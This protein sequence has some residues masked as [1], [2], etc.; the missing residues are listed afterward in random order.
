MS[1]VIKFRAWGDRNKV[2]TT[3]YIWLNDENLVGQSMISAPSHVMQFTGL[4]DKNGVEIYEGD[5][6]KTVS[7]MLRPFDRSV[8]TRTGEYV[9]KFREIEYKTSKSSFGFV[10][11]C[12]TG[13]SQKHATKWLEV[14]GNIHENPELLK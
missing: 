9:T 10:D 7:E 4:I 11:S 13:I 5:I 14:V 6:T 12:M 2:M 8:K 3:P 1:R